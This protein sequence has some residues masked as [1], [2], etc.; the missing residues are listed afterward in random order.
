[1]LV[2]RSLTVD[3]LSG[4]LPCRPSKIDMQC[5]AV[6]CSPPA[7]CEQGVAQQWIVPAI[8][9]VSHSTRHACRVFSD[10]LAAGGIVKAIRVPDGQRISNA[11]VKPKG[12]IAGA[13]AIQILSDAK[14]TIV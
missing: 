7:C 5:P 2:I 12:D 6:P 1:M 10:A 9:T 8:L 4:S 14:I 11:R 13:V 3:A